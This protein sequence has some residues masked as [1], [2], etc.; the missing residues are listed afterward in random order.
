MNF[1]SDNAGGVHP[2]IMAALVA[3]NEGHLPS[4]GGDSVTRAAQNAIRQVFEAPDAAVHFVMSGTAANALSL[5]LLTPGWGKVF[6]HETAHIQTSETGAPEFFTN[7][8]KLITVPGVGGKI[9]PEALSHA[10]Q[11]NG[12]DSVHSGQSTALSLTNATEWGTVYDLAEIT[13]LTEMAHA[14]GLS[15]HMD[16]ARF[17]NALV[18]GNVS[19]ADLTWRAG[20]DILSFGGTKNG[21]MGVETVILFDPAKSEEFEFRRKRGGQLSSK[22]RYLSAQI[23]GWLQDGLW[24]DLARHANTMAAELAV[25]LAGLKGVSIDQRV[26]TNTVFATLP[27]ALHDKARAAGAAYHLWPHDQDEAGDGPVS[28]RLVCGWDTRAEDVAAFLQVLA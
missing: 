4:Y 5:S 9:T 10:M 24:L 19:A 18:A 23:L 16:G 13:Q 21:C 26:Q 28:I 8:A 22:H 1:S 14:A 17:T 12:R 20:V 2:Q 25:G 3:A 27:R 15:V 11:V 7:G 6:C